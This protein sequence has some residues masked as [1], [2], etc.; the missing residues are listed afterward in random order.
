MRHSGSRALLRAFVVI[1]CAALAAGPAA[2]ISAGQI[3]TFE[4]ESLSGWGGG[5]HPV[6]IPEDGPAGL[7]DAHLRLGSTNFALGTVNT[8]QWTGDYIA[9]GVTAISADLNNFG[10]VPLAIR[11]VVFGLGGTFASNDE[12]ILPPSSGWISVQYAID[13]AQMTRVG[14]GAASFDFALANVTNL[15]FRHD[16][17]PISAPGQQDTVTGTFGI[18]N[19]TALPVPEPGSAE[20]IGIGL[21]ALAAKRRHRRLRSRTSVP[22]IRLH[23]LGMRESQSPESQTQKSE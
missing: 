14:P 4:N 13:E 22:I 23:S 9:A 5:S 18:D 7:D 6:I 1:W 20:L 21:A 12:V 19:I 11:M 2:A 3:D 16:P 8:V 17:D 15:L 10:S